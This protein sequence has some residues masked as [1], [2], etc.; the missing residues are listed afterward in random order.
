ML[1]GRTEKKER[2]GKRR[3]AIKVLFDPFYLA[4]SKWRFRSAGERQ[5]E[6]ERERAGVECRGKS[7][8]CVLG[9]GGMDAVWLLSSIPF[10]FG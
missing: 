1:G 2:K 10:S 9:W 4:G 8:R 3:R 6:R 7:N 5:S